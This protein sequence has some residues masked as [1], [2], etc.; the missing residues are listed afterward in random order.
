MDSTQ[1]QDFKILILNFFS[2]VL[3]EI[4]TDKLLKLLNVNFHNKLVQVLKTEFYL[5]NE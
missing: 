4:S 5:K 1:N 2:K 3:T